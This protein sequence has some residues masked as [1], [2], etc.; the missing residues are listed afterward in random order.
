MFREGRRE[1]TKAHTH[2]TARHHFDSLIESPAP[3]HSIQRGEKTASSAP[4]ECATEGRQCLPCVYFGRGGGATKSG[5]NDET[6]P[7][8]C[9]S[10]IPPDQTSVSRAICPEA[11]A[12][13]T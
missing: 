3:F 5:A 6:C 9:H 4:A 12:C 8:A 1:P 11:I 2:A 7:A 13:L 10:A